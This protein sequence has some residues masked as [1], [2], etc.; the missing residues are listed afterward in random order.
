MCT[1]FFFF[2]WE[3]EDEDE[4]GML[5]LEEELPGKLEDDDRPL[6]EDDEDPGQLEEDDE[7][8][9]D[10]LGSLELDTWEDM[11]LRRLRSSSS[12]CAHAP[13]AR[14]SATVMTFLTNMVLG[15]VEVL[16]AGSRLLGASV[17]V[18]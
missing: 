5:L 18:A 6:E 3:E 11:E 7:R 8:P 2:G 14:S 16:V 10:E 4:E 17:G 13:T 15:G 9:L 12:A 1:V